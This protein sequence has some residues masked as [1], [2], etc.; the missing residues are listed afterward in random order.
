MH[1]TGKMKNA[2]LLIRTAPLAGEDPPLGKED[3]TTEG[4]PAPTS[5]RA[6]RDSFEGGGWQHRAEEMADDRKRMD[7]LES[8]RGEF[9]QKRGLSRI[10][11]QLALLWSYTNAVASGRYTE[12]PRRAYVKVIACLLYVI[13]P[14]DL[15][16][17]IFPWIGW[18]DDIAV[19][20]YVCT[21]VREELDR[22]TQ[23][24]QRPGCTETS[25]GC[26][27]D[28]VSGPTPETGRRSGEPQEENHTIR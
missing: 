8:L 28:A 19:V 1:K 9:T 24:L 13:S 15:I 16:P 7:Y 25:S 18:I 20:L 12:S 11:R 14:F 5:I 2:P 6:A 17:D 23:W 26:K 4:S 10:R 21:L 3:P 27:Q 22:F